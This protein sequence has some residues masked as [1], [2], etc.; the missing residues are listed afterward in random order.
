MVSLTAVRRSRSR[1]PSYRSRRQDRQHVIIDPYQHLFHNAGWDAITSAGLNSLCT[2]LAERSQLA[3]P[4][5]V[6]EG[7]VAD[8]AFVDGS[9]LFHN[10]FVDLYFL[11]ELVR[12]GGLV[13]LDDCHWPSVATAVRYFEMN[14]GWRTSTIDQPTDFAPSDCRTLAS[15]RASRASSPFRMTRFRDDSERAHTRHIYIPGIPEPTSPNSRCGISPPRTRS[16][17]FSLVKHRVRNS[18]TCGVIVVSPGAPIFST[19]HRG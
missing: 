2:L 10:V 19:P 17:L 14:T 1:R 8:A 4:R 5:L 18:M 3:L 15:N 11:R 6:T 16:H 13:V 12:P 7:F 9:H